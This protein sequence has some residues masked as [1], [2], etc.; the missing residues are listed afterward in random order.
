M[1][2]V[3]SSTAIRPSEL[4]NVEI[5]HQHYVYC[6]DHLELVYRELLVEVV[7]EKLQFVHSLS[8]EADDDSL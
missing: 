7:E 4:T 3:S 8:P 6:I 1:D 5:H 2:S